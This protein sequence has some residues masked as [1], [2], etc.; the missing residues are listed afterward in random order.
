MEPVPGTVAKTYP[1]RGPLQQ[2]RFFEGIAFRCFRCGETKKSKLVT[3]YSGSWTKKLC[4]GCYG[5]LLSLYDVKAGAADT[6]EKAERL[7]ELLLSLASVDAQREATR[8]FQA[9]NNRASSLSAEALRFIATAEHVAAHL[10]AGA[11]LEW[12][13][14]V[15]GLCKAVEAEVVGRIVKPIASAAAREDLSADQKD[16]DVARVAAYCADTRRKPPELGSFA[17]FL[18]TA[19]HSQERRRSSRLILAFLKLSTQWVGSTWILEPTGLHAALTQLTSRFRNRAAHIDELSKNDYIEC[20]DL[21]VGADGL[22]W[23][24]VVATELHR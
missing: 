13:P 24:L 6:D 11:E 3:V 9:A 20:R 10:D 14:A 12:S 19:A 23:R 17:H 15:I 16:K 2:Y 5:R 21:A 7:A 4:N 18:Q 1:A 8:R 22:I